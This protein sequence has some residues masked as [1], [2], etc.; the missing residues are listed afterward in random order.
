MP[1]VF[2]VGSTSA[3][4]MFLGAFVPGLLLVG[5]YMIYILGFA[6]LKPSAAP[7]FL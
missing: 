5:I 2:D 1:S 4:E 7:G 6:L 3:G